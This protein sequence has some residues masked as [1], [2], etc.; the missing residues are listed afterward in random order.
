[1]ATLLGGSR[2]D[3]DYEDNFMTYNNT[4]ELTNE[5]LHKL[6]K[7]YYDKIAPTNLPE[8]EI[9]QGGLMG[10]ICPKCGAVMSPFEPCCVKC[11]GNFEITY[12]GTGTPPPQTPITYCALEQ[13][14]EYNIALLG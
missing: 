12:S 3:D 6:L 4:P 10:W 1:M 11:S 8:P 14:E 2:W 7:A 13:N 9:L 5:E